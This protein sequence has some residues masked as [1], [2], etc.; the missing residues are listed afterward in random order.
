MELSRSG[1]S[2][3]DPMYSPPGATFP[4]GKTV[5]RVVASS[6]DRLHPTLDPVSSTPWSTTTISR[7]D[8]LSW[9]TSLSGPLAPV[10]FQWST[11]SCN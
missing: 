5:S 3:P 2:I 8:Q 1:S 10:R 4:Q 7:M 9:T 11:E 6:P